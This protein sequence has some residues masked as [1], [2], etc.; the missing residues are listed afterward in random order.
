MKLKIF[1]DY[2]I[3][4]IKR[5]CQNKSPFIR[6]IGN[7]TEKDNFEENIKEYLTCPYDID[8]NLNVPEMTVPI[9]TIPETTIPITTLPETIVPTTTLPETKVLITALPETIIPITALLET[10]FPITTIFEEIVSIITVPE[11]KISVP[12]LTTNIST[13][14]IYNASNGTIIY[15]KVV[16]AYPQ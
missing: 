7:C 12:T 1:I 10:I 15:K 11:I 4:E 3:D 6:D 16:M 9:T 13:D 5:I 2:S 8:I 14:I